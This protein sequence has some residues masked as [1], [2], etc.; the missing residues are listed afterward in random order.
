M[1]ALAPAAALSGS[2]A[3]TTNGLLHLFPM[4]EL[5]PC[6]P[7]ERKGT[8]NTKERSAG[9]K[10]FLENANLQTE[11][12]GF[13]GAGRPIGAFRTE[14]HR[15]RCGDAGSGSR[16]RRC[17]DRRITRDNIHLRWKD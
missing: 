2:T 1:Q 13:D 5:L 7:R 8:E 6:P 9:P 3:A 17:I 10:C 14:V 12:A 11:A 16:S 4:L 15:H